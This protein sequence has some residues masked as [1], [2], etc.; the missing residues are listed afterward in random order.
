MMKRNIFSFL[1]ICLLASRLV[2]SNPISKPVDPNEGMWLPHLVQALNIGDM[3]KLGFRLSAEDL[4]SINKSSIKD[5]VVQLGGF[6]TAEV[7]SPEGLL[8]T[9]H[10]CGYDA[11]AS[12]SSV[13]H[14]YLTDGFWAKTKGEELSNPGLTVSFLVRIEDMTKRINDVANSANAEE[15]DAKIGEEIEKIEAEAVNEEAAAAGQRCEVKPMFNGNEFYLFIYETF[16]DVRL[17]GAPPSSIGKFGGDTDNWMWPRH[18][19][20]FSIMRVYANKDNK[21]AD[22]SPDN[23]PYTPKHY[24]P[25]SVRGVK[26]GDFSMTLG[27]PGS[28]ERYLTSFAIDQAY[29]Y[30]N[31]TIVKILGERLSIMKEFMDADPKVR[32]Q[33]ASSY[34]S[35][36]NSHK[37]YIGQNRG[38]DRR[39]L[40]EEKTAYEKKWSN[41]VNSDNTRKEKYGKVLETIQQNYATHGDALKLSSYMNMAGFGP[42]FVGYGV[43]LWRLKATME[44]TPDNKEAW[45][46]VLDRINGGK[47]D[48]FKEFHPATDQKILA[49]MCR[50]LKNDLKPE[51]QPSVFSEKAFTKSKAKGDMDQFDVY[52]EKVFSTSI[53]TNQARLDAFLAN[54]S[55]KVLDADLGVAHVA[56]IITLY[57]EKMI[58]GRGSFDVVNDEAMRL[59]EDAMMKMAPEKKFYPDANFTMRMSYGKVI[60]YDPRD[61]V[62]YKLQTY[63]E[64]I[65]EKEIPKDEEFDVPTK[66]HDLLKSKDFGP[67]GENGQLPVCF[68]SDNDITG[69]NSG[70]PVINGDGQLIGIA[71]D[72]N[73]ESMTGDL[74]Y[75]ADVQRT[76]SVDIRYVLFCI[77]KYAGATNLISELKIV[78]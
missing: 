58:P 27:Y 39:G 45:A 25:I 38:L 78:K 10:H 71:F 11:I 48:F 15:R 65:L 36:A 62:A 68:L 42:A 1:W 23:V 37:Y 47:A 7:V 53:I 34:A 9:N 32:I 59:F 40:F 76:I 51:Y 44:K 70:S 54:P 16:R 49:A 67:Y 63:G 22:Y 21:P 41:W 28:T 12:H 20:D 24:L 74:V 56:S 18:T 60:P 46:P 8:F 5:A 30:D 4:Y 52:A 6:C 33:M 50:F 61:G 26:E 57:R 64:G 55:K 75:D 19:G 77:E 43:N 17:V 2:A 73:W 35:L 72:G 31:P 14:D 13:E 3:Q 29:K 69:G 66:L